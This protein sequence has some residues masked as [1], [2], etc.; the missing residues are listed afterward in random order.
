[1][2]KTMTKL[3]QTAGGIPMLKQI[4]VDNGKATATDMDYS[5]SVPCSLENGMYHGLGFEKG[6]HNKSTMEKKDFPNDVPQIQKECRAQTALG[7]SYIEHL[8]W[9]LKAASREESR[10]YLNGIF[11]DWTENDGVIVATDGHRLHSFE[12]QINGERPKKIQ[13]KV[14]GKMKTIKQLT[15]KIIHTRGIKIIISLMKEYKQE[16]A[17]NFYDDTFTATI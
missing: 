1:M 14:D 7:L 8:E 10:Y 5:I 12:H 15:G 13:K 9:V 3:T 4:K 11:F 16:A 2:F 6:M 17:I